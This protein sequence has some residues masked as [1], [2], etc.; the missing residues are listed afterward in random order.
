MSDLNRKFH[1]TVRDK[2]C[3]TLCVDLTVIIITEFNIQRKKSIS[4][5]SSPGLEDD[6]LSVYIVVVY[7]LHSFQSSF[8]LF[9]IFYHF[10]QPTGGLMSYLD[11]IVYNNKSVV[12]T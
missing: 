4:D 12:L 8:P 5:E 2:Y 6:P 7:A 1:Q 3:R 10:S 9:F 11:F